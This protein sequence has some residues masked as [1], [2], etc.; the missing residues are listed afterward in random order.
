M[1]LNDDDA[2]NNRCPEFKQM[3]EDIIKKDR[4]TEMQD[5]SQRAAIKTLQ[6]NETQNEKTLFG[7]LRPLVIPKERTIKTTKHDLEGELV[8][9]L[10]EYGD[11]GLQ[12]IEDC[13][14]VKSLVPG[15]D[16]TNEEKAMGITDPK[17]DVTFGLRE[18][19]FPD[20][21]LRLPNGIQAL[22]GVAPG[23]QHAFFVIEH[24]SIEESIG[25]AE[26]QATRD[27][28]VLVKARMLL[29]QHVQSAGYV[30]QIGADDSSFVFSCAWIPDYAKIYVHWFEKL[31]SG[32]EIYHM[33]LLHEYLMRRPEEMKLFRRHVQNIMDWG[34]LT[35]KMAN[36][37]MY[38]GLVKMYGPG[39]SAYASGNDAATEIDM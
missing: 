8:L 31:A 39:G 24:K 28:A 34:L 15:K 9:I 36:D 3:V 4:E 21:N 10:R 12:K 16:F 19:Q 20:S 32:V 37:A 17:P 23:M 35:R 11:D 38:D 22:L 14:F 5:R 30:Q 2:F 6:M 27:G 13:Q 29:H 1:R 26:V 33:N 25:L 7:D 18:P